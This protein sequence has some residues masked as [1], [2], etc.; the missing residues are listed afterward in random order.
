MR[1]AAEP[2]GPQVTR[3]GWAPRARASC[4]LPAQCWVFWRSTCRS[5]TWH[6]CRCASA[7]LLPPTV[8]EGAVQDG[9]KQRWPS[10]A[11]QRQVEDAVCSAHASAVLTFDARGVSGHP[12]HVDTHVGVL[13]WAA[14]QQQGAAV[15]CWLLVRALLLCGTLHRAHPVSTALRRAPALRPS[16]RARCWRRSRRWPPHA[17]EAP[18]PASLRPHSVWRAGRWR[19]I[20][21][22]TCGSAR[23]S[24]PLPRAPSPTRS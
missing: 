14:A 2:A 20:A 3:L 1:P 5:W 18:V 13:A 24:S 17:A 8:T 10:D 6:S 4:L 19:S 16:S 7:Q 22:S 21:A 23:C 15:E 11:V 9:M 12:N